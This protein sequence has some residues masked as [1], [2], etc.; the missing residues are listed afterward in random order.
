[1]TKT[2][3]AVSWLWISRAKKV[4]QDKSIAY[5]TLSELYKNL[6]FLIESLKVSVRIPNLNLKEHKSVFFELKKLLEVEKSLS[7]RLKE[8]EL[9]EEKPSLSLRQELIAKSKKLTSE[10][11]KEEIKII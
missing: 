5:V 6:W 10:A 9:K 1:M 2:D 8:L 11:L 3:K 7:E 4:L